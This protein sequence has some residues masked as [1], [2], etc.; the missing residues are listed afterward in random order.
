MLVFFAKGMLYR[1][2]YVLKQISDWFCQT[3]SIN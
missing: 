2:N 3:S 1:L